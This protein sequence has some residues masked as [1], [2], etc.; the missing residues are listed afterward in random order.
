M[1]WGLTLFVLMIWIRTLANKK[2]GYSDVASLSRD[3]HESITML[4]TFVEIEWFT[5]VIQ[6]V[7]SADVFSELN[8]D[9]FCV[10]WSVWYI[11]QCL[12]YA[13]MFLVAYPRSQLV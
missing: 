13:L 7:R 10:E 12:S 2:F 8:T 1:T 3:M 4:I 5:L 6:G 9:V 11:I